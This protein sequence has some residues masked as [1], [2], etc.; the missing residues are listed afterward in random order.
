[1]SIAPISAIR[2]GSIR[3]AVA[4][5]NIANINTA[6]ARAQRVRVTEQ[7]HLGGVSAQVETGSQGPNLIDATIEQISAG[8]YIKANV[9]TLRIQNEMVGSL[10]D[11]IA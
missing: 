4:S 9:Q 2:A 1:M 6:Q 11:L 3:M 5:H 10:I 8:N 7:A